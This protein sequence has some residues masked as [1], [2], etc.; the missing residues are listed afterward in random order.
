MTPIMKSEREILLL[1][2]GLK[3]GL[4]E[5]DTT[6]RARVLSKKYGWMSVYNFDDEPRQADYYIFEAKRIVESGINIDLRLRDFENRREQNEKK[7]Q[8]FLKT[9]KK[10]L[11]KSQIEFMHQTGYLR[12]TREEVRDRLTTL[13]AKLYEAIAREVGFSLKEVINLSSEEIIDLLFEKIQDKE[14]LR[15]AAKRRL[16]RYAL[17]FHS[18]KIKVFDIDNDIDKA[19]KKIETSEDVVEIRGQSASISA[20]VRGTVRIVQSNKEVNKVNER[21]I[22]VAGMTKP[23]YIGAMKKAVAF[24]TD[25]GGLT[26]HAAIVARE[27]KIPCIVGTKIATKVLK[28][29]M[30]VEVDADKGIVRINK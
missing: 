28:D 11:L 24:V 5:S 12:D 2:K 19:V 10:L 15:Q 14:K 17:T 27:L 23:D 22:L 6:K 20:V 9:I 29:G 1:A 26:S 25:E 30:V 13:A 3:N 8:A 4:K 21:D 18:G 16:E 7:Y